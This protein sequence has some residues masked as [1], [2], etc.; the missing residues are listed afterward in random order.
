VL[1]GAVEVYANHAWVIIGSTDW[2]ELGGW[3]AALPVNADAH[4]VA[5]K[6]RGQVAHTRV[7]FW[8][9]AMPL[10]GRVVFDGEL[11]LNDYT[12]CGGDLERNSRWL[13]RTRGHGPVG[14]LPPPGSSEAA[15]TG[16]QRVIVR[17]DDPGHASRVQVGLD[18]G[19]DPRLHSLPSAGEPRLFDVLVARE[20]DMSLPSERALALDGHDSPHARLTAAIHL[21]SGPDPSKSW[22][23]GYESNLIAEWLRWLAIDLDF[24]AAEEL[25]RQLRDLVRSS[26]SGHDGT[27]SQQDAA[28][29]A[30]T[31]LNSIT[32]HP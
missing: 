28:E 12:I 1:T 16:P 20:R 8:S 22:Q 32:H 6:S 31:I 24:P 29:I 18:I 21:L 30:I 15:G 27:V 23:E 5:I 2:P 10:H 11:D 17:V 25:G 3:A 4:H 7:S 26:R 13:M 9:G 19:S 14:R